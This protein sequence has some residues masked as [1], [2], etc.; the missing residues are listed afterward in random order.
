MKEGE[1][2]LVQFVFKKAFK[3]WQ[4]RA[5]NAVTKG[6]QISE[7]ERQSLPGEELIKQKKI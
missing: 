5:Q 2:A 7:E 6:I 4:S 1:K 3:G